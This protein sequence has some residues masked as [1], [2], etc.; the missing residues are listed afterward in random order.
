M[1]QFPSVLALL[2]CIGCLITP[3]RAS[4]LTCASA[5][6]PFEVRGEGLTERQGDV[7]LNCSDGAP[8]AQI[9]GNLFVFLSV[10]V[11]NRTSA[12]SVTDAAL[13]IDTG[14]G[15]QPSG[16]AGV[17]MNASSIAFNGITFNLSGTGS[18]IMRISNIR[19]N[20]T[21]LLGSAN[22]YVTAQLIFNGTPVSLPGAPLTTALVGR[23]LYDGLSSR[24]VCSQAG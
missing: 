10:P 24:I 13:T 7:V 2:C 20:V 23:G 3:A 19:T 4:F 16:V 14:A 5:T 8:N 1:S 18:I 9:T 12:S 15:P 21:S 11:T 22:P 6:S 17:L